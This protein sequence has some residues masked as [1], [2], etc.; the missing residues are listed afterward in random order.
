[1]IWDFQDVLSRRLLLW[2]ALSIIAG[3]LLVAFGA[4]AWWHGFGVQ[5]LA[6]G[7]IDAAIALFGQLSAR[8]RRA[9]GL[10]GPETF[11]REA[12]NLRRLLWVNTGLDVL[13]LAGGV[14]LI[15]T[16]GAQNPF[17]A[18][19]GWGVVVQGGFLFIFDLLHALAVPRRDAALPA[20]DL[21]SGAEHAAF[22]LSGGDPAAVLV[23]G[24]GGTPAEMR[25]LAEALHRQGWT[26]DVPLLP[27]FGADIAALTERRCTEWLAAVQAAGGELAAAG[28]RPLLLVGYS[29]GAGLVLVASETIR[30]AGLVVLAPFWWPEKWWTRI[31]EFIARPFL[32]IGFRPLRKADLADPRLR[33][34]LA[35]F[36]PGLDLDDPSTQAAL[37]DFRVPLGLIDQVR[38]LSRRM[39]AAV[40]AI[41][42]P[43]LVV[44]GTRD[45][46]VR[47]A[48]T[49]RLLLRFPNRPAYVEVDSE[50]DLT[51]PENP[52]WQAVEAAVVAF[53][54]S[55]E[56]SDAP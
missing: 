6:W 13:Y 2:S 34:G 10:G 33:Q 25:G 1:M 51:L 46:V 49:R 48:Q 50:H 3:A 8:K 11:A 15:R 39:L 37:R 27:G 12:R 47:T 45:S 26:V 5:A 44:Q 19:S 32:P 28:H 31:I 38:D 9:A 29:L 30:P 24:F 52:A 18:G 54:H 22:R 20:L 35:K 4:S 14:A 56:A 36:M 7:A 40:P 43:A 42:A 55:I 23:H 17:A 53:A 41:A 21:F 16:M